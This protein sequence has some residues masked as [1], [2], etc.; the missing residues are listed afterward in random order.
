MKIHSA[1][2]SHGKGPT[3]Q[4]TPLQKHVDFFVRDFDGR[5]TLGETYQGL[6]TLGAGRLLAS[7]GALLFHASLAGRSE[8]SNWTLSIDNNN[9]AAVKTGADTGIYDDHGQFDKAKFDELWATRDLDRN[10]ELSQ[11]EIE[12]MLD[13]HQGGLVSRWGS[14]AKFGLLLQLAGQEN[15]AGEPVLTRERLEQL[16]DGSL[17]YRLAAGK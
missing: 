15:A 17:F 13:E 9:I 6:R 16:Y 5:T 12:Q 1:P 14:R 8:T 4:R 7:A 2:P 3:K 11:P 10:N